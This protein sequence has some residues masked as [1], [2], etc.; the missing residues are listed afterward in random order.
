MRG[1][2]SAEVSHFGAEWKGSFTEPLPSQSRA[3]AIDALGSSYGRFAL[4]T[5]NGYPRRSRGRQYRDSSSLAV[6][7]PGSFSY[8]A[9][10]PSDGSQ[11]PRLPAVPSSMKTLRLPAPRPLRL[12]DSPAGTTC[13]L[14]VRV[15][16][17][18]PS[19]PQTVDGARGLAASRASH[20]GSFT[21]GLYRASQVPWRALPWLC[22]RSPTPADPSAPRLSRCGRCYPHCVEDEGADDVSISGLNN[23]ASPPVVYASRH[24]LPNAIPHSLPAGEL[25]LC[26]TGVEPA[27]SR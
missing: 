22:V 18:A 16:R 19:V 23:A 5:P 25:H 24:P 12:I 15:R 21:P 8:G 14:L 7:P 6:P 26:R 20:Y 3:C 13:C 17:S 4:Y 2:A 9:P 11:R 1:R 10:L 27:G